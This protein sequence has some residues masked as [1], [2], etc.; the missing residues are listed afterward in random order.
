MSIGILAYLLFL[1]G[2]AS[3]APQNSQNLP[4]GVKL[5][6]KPRPLIPVRLGGVFLYGLGDSADPMENSAKAGTPLSEESRKFLA[7]YCDVFALPPN[8]IT[9]KTYPAML[10]EQPLLVPLIYLS[11]STLYE[12]EDYPGNAGGWKPAALEWTLRD[13]KGAEIPHPDKGGHWMDLGSK[14]WAEH[15]KLQAGR[16]TRTFGALGVVAAE[17]MIGNPFLP[18][19]LAKYP[20]LADRG[21]ATAQW[22]RN[23]RGDFNIFPSSTGFEQLVGHSITSLAENYRE[24]ELQG[25]FWDYLHPWCDGAWGEGWL[26]PYWSEYALPMETRRVQ[27]AAGKRLSKNGGTFIATAAYHNDGELES[28]LAYY[29]LVSHKQGNMVFQ[30]MPILPN[31]PADAGLSLAVLRQQVKEK[32]NLLQPPLGWANEEMVHVACGEGRVVLRRRYTEGVVY[33]NVDDRNVAHLNLGS[34]LRRTSGEK[35]SFIDL[36]PNSGVILYNPPRV[37]PKKPVQ[38]PKTG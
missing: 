26:Y 8:V 34:E 4:P 25:R 6:M 14:E 18:E 27:M 15:W 2:K 12:L 10:K 22:L 11:A 23:A 3:P 7:A 17:L 36:A 20:T 28:L 31:A 5:V 16:K 30:P 32:P 35:V 24:P 1:L 13:E 9:P 38:K 21:E 29:L 19:K 37:L 33:V